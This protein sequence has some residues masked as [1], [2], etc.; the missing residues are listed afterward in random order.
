MPND[1]FPDWEKVLAAAARLQR[2][3]PGAALVGWQNWQA[4]KTA[5]ANCAM[6][7]FDRIVGLEG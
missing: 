6:L 4:V 1:S 7:I 2:I 5:C 3:L